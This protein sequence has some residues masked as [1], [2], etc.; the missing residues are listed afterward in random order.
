M[1]LLVVG[2]ILLVAIVYLA[3]RQ[4]V[5]VPLEPA[6]Q[7]VFS[8]QEECEEATAGS[9]KFEMCDYV[10][11]GRTP[12]EVCPPSGPYK[13]WVSSRLEDLQVTE[14][15]LVSPLETVSALRSVCQVD[16][17]C[18]TFDQSC[19]FCSCGTPIN[20]SYLGQYEAERLDRCRSY[21]GGVC[22]MPCPPQEVKCIDLRCQFVPTFPKG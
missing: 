2:V 6:Q 4:Y 18:M 17:D 15:P 9:C 20:K 14:G 11:R 7:N 21:Q 10:P 1:A 5:L 12:E 16:D 8:S 13:G 19:D 22:S 3:L